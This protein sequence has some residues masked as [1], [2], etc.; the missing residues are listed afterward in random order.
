[1]KSRVLR[2]RYTY[3]VGISNVAIVFPSALNESCPIVEIFKV[4]FTESNATHNMCHCHI[5]VTE[6]KFMTFHI[7]KS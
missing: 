2:K 7:P 4:I 5:R 3:M 1:M 6:Q